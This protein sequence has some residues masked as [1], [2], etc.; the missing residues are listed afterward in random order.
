VAAE[1][2]PSVNFSWPVNLFIGRGSS[3]C[4]IYFGYSSVEKMLGN[5]GLKRKGDRRTGG[6]FSPCDL[7]SD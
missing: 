3:G 7:S 1:I 6:T 2:L 5:T 4:E